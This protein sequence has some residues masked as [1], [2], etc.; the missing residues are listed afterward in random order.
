LYWVKT[1]RVFHSLFYTKHLQLLRNGENYMNFA[2]FFMIVLISSWMIFPVI[3]ADT[4]DQVNSAGA[5]YSKSVDL[6]NAGKYSEA[7]EVSDEALALNVTSLIPLIQA[8][9]AGILVMLARFDEANAAADA[10]LAIEGNLTSVHS[11]AWFNKGNALRALGRCDEAKTAYDRATGLDPTLVPPD[12][13]SCT[14]PA[15][16]TPTKS[17]LS[18]FPVLVALATF[19]LVSVACRNKGK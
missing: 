7:L 8:N 1:G 19:F 12:L 6:A 17:P 18:W 11:V 2:R 10:A 16:P 13:N 9:R 14:S 4:P 3:A 15:L 5:L